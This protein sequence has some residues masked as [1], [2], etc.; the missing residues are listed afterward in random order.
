MQNNTKE[1]KENLTRQ[2]KDLSERRRSNISSVL[3]RWIRPF[4]L[5]YV[6]LHAHLE[7]AMHGAE[8]GRVSFDPI[9]HIY[10]FFQVKTCSVIGFIKHVSMQKY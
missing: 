7:G 6:A 9:Y 10:G 8:L 1:I 2:V 4:L 3:M 5:F